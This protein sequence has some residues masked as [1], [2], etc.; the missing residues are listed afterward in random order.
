MFRWIGMSAD[1]SDDLVTMS[2][3]PLHHIFRGTVLSMFFC[4][5]GFSRPQILSDI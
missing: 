1:V 2:Q 5:V 4:A 3:P